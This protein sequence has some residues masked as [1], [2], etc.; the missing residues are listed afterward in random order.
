MQ[1][2]RDFRENKKD[3]NDDPYYCVGTENTASPYMGLSPILETQYGFLIWIRE[4]VLNFF[5]PYRPIGKI[6]NEYVGFWVDL[7]QWKEEAAVLVSKLKNYE[8]R[9]GSELTVHGPGALC[10]NAYVIGHQE[11]SRCERC[12]ALRACKWKFTPMRS[13]CRCGRGYY[14]M[15]TG[16][17]IIIH[18]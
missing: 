7:W 4:E 10:E 8:L 16:G 15:L 6:V 14:R 9:I 1:T 5:D 11:L 3:K 2:Y 12:Q 13:K 18:G 17:W